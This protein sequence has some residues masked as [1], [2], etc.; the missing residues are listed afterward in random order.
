MRQNVFRKKWISAFMSAVMV[1]SILFVQRMPAGSVLMSDDLRISQQISSH[2][3]FSPRM[4]SEERQSVRETITD[5]QSSFIV[6]ER[7]TELRTAARSTQIQSVL[8]TQISSLF[9]YIEDIAY[10]HVSGT[11]ESSEV[12][13][14]YMHRQDGKKG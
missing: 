9:Y 2:R 13:L 10:R 8:M 7:P 11:T 1:L 5:W 3:M 12:I 4:P 14:C 6:R